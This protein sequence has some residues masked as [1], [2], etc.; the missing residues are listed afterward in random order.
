MG[1]K[2]NLKYCPPKRLMNL[3][4]TKSKDIL[5][6]YSQTFEACGELK[7]C[8]DQRSLVGSNI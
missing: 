7:I 6:M 5:N 1:M 2:S 4:I 3:F 8:N